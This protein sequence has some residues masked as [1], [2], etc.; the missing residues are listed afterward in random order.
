MIKTITFILII[1]LCCTYFATYD[2]PPVVDDDVQSEVSDLPDDSEQQKEQ[3]SEPPAETQKPL[4]EDTQDSADVPEEPV[5][6]PEEPVTTPEEPVTPPEEPVTPPAEPV[7]PP[8]ESVTPPAEP[9]TPPAEP[10]TPPAPENVADTVRAKAAEAINS[11]VTAD[12]SEYQKLRA[13][14]EWLFN[15]FRYRTVWVDLTY[16]ITDEMTYDLSSYYFKYH[17]GSC[18]HYAAA[19][20]VL[21]EQM[22]YQVMYVYGQ[23]YAAIEGAYGTHVWVMIN[24]NG[25]WYHVDGLYSGNHTYDITSAFLVPDWEIESHHTWDRTAY[26]AC[27]TPKYFG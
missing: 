22:G 15:H 2:A 6:T 9:V 25:N 16:G 24:L 12:M 11:V 3:Q 23:R 14:Y 1:V 7:T 21:F 17:K 4:F 26:P 5:T 10:V 19:Q 13:V 20:K 8:A 27:V 18:E